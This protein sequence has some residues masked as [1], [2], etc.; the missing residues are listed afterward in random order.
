ML[1]F[2]TSTQ[3]ALQ[4]LGLM[5]ENRQMLTRAT[6]LAEKIGKTYLYAVKVLGMLKEKGLVKSEQGC[7]GGYCLARDPEKI[8]VYD[9]VCAV[10]NEVAICNDKMAFGDRRLKNYFTN[11]QE[12]MVLSLKRESILSLFADSTLT[13]TTARAHHN[14]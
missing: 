1:K 13:K 10:D 2:Q 8:S 4:M 3:Y 14:G 9:V 12:A 6:D 5:Y 7:N 11:L